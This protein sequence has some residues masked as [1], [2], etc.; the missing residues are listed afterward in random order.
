MKKFDLNGA[1]C[2]GK[3]S[4]MA[5]LVIDMQHQWCSP[6]VGM[7]EGVGPN[8]YFFRRISN[9]CKQTRK[10][11]DCFRYRGDEVM[12]VT[13]GSVT[14]NGREMSTDFKM[15]GAVMHLTS[16]KR[17]AA[18][19]EEVAPQGDEIV[20][21]K[22]STSVFNSTNIDYL[23]RNLG[24]RCIVLCGVMT[25]YC[26]E[27]AARDAADKGYFVV[28]VEDCCAADTEEE[29]KA[30]IAVLE[31]YSNVRI[32]SSVQILLEVQRLQR[33]AKGRHICVVPEPVP[34]PVTCSSRRSG[35]LGTRVLLTAVG[36][37]MLVTI[38]KRAA[39]CG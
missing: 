23:L 30:A 26:V 16:E 17:E 1:L 2:P 9:V 31:G 20:V 13:I 21:A 38:A 14:T 36:L 29:H 18:I 39:L 27:S 15:A 25:N 37:C 19:L 33:G 34:V 22:S 28:V 10:M 4:G 11:Q 7:H 32:A 24:T 35:E 8:E 5:L 6:G 3:G 12:F